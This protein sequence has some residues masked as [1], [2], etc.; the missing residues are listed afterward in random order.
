ME[1]DG[2]KRWHVDHDPRR[3]RHV[4]PRD[5][6]TVGT[7]EDLSEFL[8]ELAQRVS[9]GSIETEHGSVAGYVEAASG[10]VADLPGYFANRDE[11]MPDEPDWSLV[12]SI[13]LAAMV[14]E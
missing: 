11:P 5:P 10:W 3:W 9:S 1:E 2:H 4:A 14:Y 8:R 13:F 6:E 12:A 7:R